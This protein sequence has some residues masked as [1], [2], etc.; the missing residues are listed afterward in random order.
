MRSTERGPEQQRSSGYS[1]FLPVEHLRWAVWQN[2]GSYVWVTSCFNNRCHFGSSLGLS[3][4]LFTRPPI[5]LFICQLPSRRCRVTPAA[6]GRWWWM[7]RSGGVHYSP[8]M[9]PAPYV[10][11]GLGP[12]DPAQATWLQRRSAHCLKRCE[13]RRHVGKDPFSL[14][15]LAPRGEGPR[16]AAAWR[17][18]PLCKVRCRHTTGLFGKT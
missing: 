17:F 3:G 7:P 8:L 9:V 16:P 4:N 12:A 1:L 15:T 13:C 5:A 10:L 11:P 14:E 6:S 2:L 18:P